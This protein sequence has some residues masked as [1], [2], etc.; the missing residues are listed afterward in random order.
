[1]SLCLTTCF[2]TSLLM[3]SCYSATIL[4]MY[5]SHPLHSCRTT[6]LSGFQ[7]AVPLTVILLLCPRH[8][9][10]VPAGMKVLNVLSL[11]THTYTHTLYPRARTNTRNQFSIYSGVGNLPAPSKHHLPVQSWGTRIWQQQRCMR[12][13]VC[14][15]V[16]KEWHKKTEK[17]I[18]EE[19]WKMQ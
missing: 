14:V 4:W 13:W 10:S 5:L 18:G 11:T 15:C 12:M 8:V 17:V 1:M 6:F 16:S 7:C 9:L 19:R 2:P 3:P